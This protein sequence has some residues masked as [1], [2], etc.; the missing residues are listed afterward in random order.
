MY[1][2]HHPQ[3]SIIYRSLTAPPGL[4]LATRWATGP[5]A[6]RPPQ[7]TAVDFT[8]DVVFLRLK[9]GGNTWKKICV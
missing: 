7:G 1:I 9:K 8:W 4:R 3:P 2:N 5:K 6:R